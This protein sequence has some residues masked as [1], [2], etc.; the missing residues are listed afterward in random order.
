MIVSTIIEFI[1]EVF[2][3]Y[4]PGIFFSSLAI[5]IGLLTYFFGGKK[6]IQLMETSYESLKQG[7][8]KWISEFTLDKEGSSGRTYLI[9]TKTGS[10][11][12]DVRVHFLL[13]PRH[14]MVSRVA[15]R[16]KKRRD[17]V[18][19]AADPSNEVL[20]RYQMEIFPKKNQ[21]GIKKLIDIL[22]KLD[23]YETGNKIM[24]ETLLIK[25]N[26]KEIINVIFQ[27]DKNIFRSLYTLRDNIERI[28]FYPFE[29]PSIRF[30]VLL[31]DRLQQ[32]LFINFVF[33]FTAIMTTLAK[34]EYFSKPRKTSLGLYRD[35]TD[36]K[37]K[38]K[39][40]VI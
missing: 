14:L 29:S 28:S 11:I 20:K 8:K 38:D 34:K 19:I 9:E 1:V 40:F 16:L 12:E 7:S 37:D 2:L 21:K 23:T 13:V 35:K 18:F 31:N 4:F 5:V 30:I 24:D 27:Q 3:N 15:A 36:A 25:I 10:P 32:K 39:R 6:N 26:D 22:D 17:F 33:N